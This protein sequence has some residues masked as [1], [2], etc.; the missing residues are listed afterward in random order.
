MRRIVALLVVAA[1]G[2]LAAAAPGCSPAAKAPSAPASA[3]ALAGTAAPTSAVDAAGACAHVELPAWSPPMSS[4]YAVEHGDDGDACS[5]GTDHLEAA[6][7]AALAALGGA[8]APVA[9]AWDRAREPLRLDVVQRRL[10]LTGAELAALRA[11]GFVVLEKQRF[12]TYAEA[13]H[14]IYQ[15][16]L[17]LWVS[18]DAVLHAVYRSNDALIARVE[19]SS[20][21]PTLDAA[22]EKIHCALGASAASYP[23]DVARDADLY[24]TVARSLLAGTAVP[25]VLGDDAAAKALVARAMAAEGI[26]S[27][28]LFGRARMVDFSVYT[29]RG[30]YAA[31]QASSNPGGADLSRYFRAATWL[32]RLELNLATYD[33]A[34]SSQGDRA[35]TPREATV[36]LAL[37]ELIARSGATDGVAALDKAWSLFAGPREDVSFAQVSSL[38]AEADVVSASQPGAAERLRKTLGHRFPRTARTHYT[39]EGCSDLPAIATMLGARVVPDAAVTRPL[40]HA[41][42]PGRQRLGI[43]DM[44]YA[45]GL[46][47]AKT[48]LASDLAKHPALGG[49]LEKARTLAH[50]KLAGE[51]L[52]SAW[53]SAVRGVAEPPQGTLPSFMRTD[54][55]DDLRLGTIAAGFGQI[56]H[57]YVLMAAMT[58]GEAGCAIPDAFVEPAP[59]VYAGLLDYASR[60][61]SAM[62]VIGTP[63]DAEYFGRLRANLQLLAAVGKRELEGKPL[64]DEALRFLSMVVEVT[65]GTRTTGSAPTFTGWYF[66][67]FRAREDALDGASFLADYYTST[68]LGEAAY[69]GVRDVRLGV[70]V[71]D[72]GGA[73]RVVVGP[74]SDSFEAHEPLPRLGDA[75]VVKVH[76]EAPWAKSYVAAALPEPPLTLKGRVKDAAGKTDRVT[77]TARSTRALGPVTIELLD[78]HRRP[79]AS[80]THPVGTAPVAFTFPVR[81]LPKDAS[82]ERWQGL[83]VR[84]GQWDA[85]ETGSVGPEFGASPMLDVGEFARGYGGMP[86]A[87]VPVI[88]HRAGLE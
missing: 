24:L 22:L 74:V 53:F 86:A 60:G 51:D 77:L 5:V 2:V 61:E 49:Q 73:P 8:G 31:S 58:Y 65:Y 43:A 27:V 63:E 67:M 6:R 80:V 10:G 41:D 7:T 9:A 42:V 79:F 56:R 18:T 52:Y 23:P 55:Y 32:S 40:V 82:T 62:E 50:A 21:E 45:F 48:Y 64:P 20:L 85:W 4:A 14:E 37:A 87:K 57:N 83:H 76:A 13:L 88:D 34:S 84:V 17:P 78:H 75:D 66:D 26:E 16:E 12:G 3:P 69:A 35:Q 38:A 30:H 59:A 44:A 36:A 47:R 71:V 11:R 54:A 1:A 19:A 39:W 46:D 29:P 15:S 70:F 81:G 68:E 28:T 25:G 33:C 72:T